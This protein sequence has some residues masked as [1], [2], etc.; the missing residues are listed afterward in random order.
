M[1]FAQQQAN[2]GITTTERMRLAFARRDKAALDS[3][4]AGYV[5]AVE[6][7]WQKEQGQP[8]GQGSASGD[9]P[10]P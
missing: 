10:S 2:L 5:D 9:Q 1:D 7:A 6:S 3:A 4:Y 8:D